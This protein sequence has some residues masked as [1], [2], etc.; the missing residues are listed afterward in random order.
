MNKCI[1]AYYFT[2]KVFYPSIDFFP[3]QIGFLYV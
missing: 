2:I 3:L 1:S